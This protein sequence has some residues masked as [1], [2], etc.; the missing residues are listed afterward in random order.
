MSIGADQLKRDAKTM[1]RTGIG[2]CNPEIDDDDDDD[3]RL[4]LNPNVRCGIF[5]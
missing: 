3:D 2:L 1:I 4:K 5:Y